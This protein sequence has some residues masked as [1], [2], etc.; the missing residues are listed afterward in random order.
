M[1]QKCPNLFLARLTGQRGRQKCPNFLGHAKMPQFIFGRL[2]G[3]RGLYFWPPYRAIG[4]AKMPQFIFGRLT[5]QRGYMNTSLN[6][7]SAKNKRALFLA[8]LQGNWGCKNA[9]IYFWPP[10]RAEVGLCALQVPV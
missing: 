8:A 2:T 4:A 10:Y 3:Q 9:P 7:L 6:K 1:L 5:G